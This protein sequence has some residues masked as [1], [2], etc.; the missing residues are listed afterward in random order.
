MARSTEKAKYLVT[1]TVTYT[2]TEQREMT[3]TLPVDDA[4]SAAE[5]K[6]SAMLEREKFAGTIVDS[7]RVYEDA[8]LDD[9]MED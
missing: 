5:E 1:Y 7:E 4:E 9:V 3:M 6:I 2:V 8:S